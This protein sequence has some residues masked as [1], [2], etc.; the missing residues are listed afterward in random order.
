MMAPLIFLACLAC[1]AFA[2]VIRDGW[3]PLGSTLYARLSGTCFCLLGGLLASFSWVGLASGLA[4]GI[5]FWTDMKHGE[6]ARAQDNIDL[7]YLFISGITSL[8]PLILLL[9]IVIS[10]W[11]LLLSLAAFKK[12]PIWLCAWKWESLVLRDWYVPTR[13]AALTWGVWVGLLVFFS[14]RGARWF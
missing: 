9:A 14:L 11:M 12:P 7:E 13:A 1:F 4:V 10:P 2:H 8:A 6:G 3:P 5:G